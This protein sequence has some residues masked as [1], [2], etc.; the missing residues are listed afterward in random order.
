MIIPKTKREW[1]GLGVHLPVGLFQVF[2]MVTAPLMGWDS[3]I[4]PLIALGVIFGVAFIVYEV[5]QGGDI[6]LDTAGYSWGIFFGLVGLFSYL[7]F[8]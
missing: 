3:L 1:Q 8:R 7:P 2:C 5:T 6:H 4:M